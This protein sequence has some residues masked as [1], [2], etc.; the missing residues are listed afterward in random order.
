MKKQLILLLLTGM[1]AIAAN[2]MA[3]K[4]HGN[5]C[6]QVFNSEGQPYWIYQFGVYEKEGGHLVL[7]GSVDYGANGIS[8]S[9]GN[10][11]IV[12]SNIK[13]TIV[14]S[15]YEDSDGEVWSETFTALLN[16][17]TLSGEWNALSLETQDGRNV[18]TVFQKGSISL[19][20][21]QS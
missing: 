14:S 21:C 17:S 1:L 12:G 16:R 10:A 11:V 18:R 7:Y 13:M 2:A 3:D 20:T 4:F 8:A 15:D 19:I 9:H 6:W 5:F